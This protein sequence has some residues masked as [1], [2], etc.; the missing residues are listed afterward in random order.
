M[1]S[2]TGSIKLP[3]SRTSLTLHW[4][5]GAADKSN[6]TNV[7]KSGATYLEG[8]ISSINHLARVTKTKCI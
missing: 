1:I 4:K 3:Q 8:G 6:E 2:R 7:I 5:R